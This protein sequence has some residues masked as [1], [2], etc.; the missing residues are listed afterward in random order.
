[1]EDDAFDA[2]SDI[3]V[4]DAA[5]RPAR[6]LTT[7][8]LGISRVSHRR[9][10]GEQRLHDFNRDGFQDANDVNELIRRIQNDGDQ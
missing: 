4:W 8:D 7:E 2:F 6:V 9:V 10:S 3:D 1:M 5:A